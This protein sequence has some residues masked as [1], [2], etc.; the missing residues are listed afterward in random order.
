MLENSEVF[1]LREVALNIGCPGE[2]E[3]KIR[4]KGRGRHRFGLEGRGQH[5]AKR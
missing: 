5:E 3:L 2:S 1:F 4:E